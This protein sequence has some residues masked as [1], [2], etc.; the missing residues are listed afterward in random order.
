[1]ATKNDH[2]DYHRLNRILDMP[3]IPDSLEKSLLDN[4]EN[5]IAENHELANKQ[6]RQRFLFSTS[7][8]ASLFLGLFVMLRINLVAPSIV[9]AYEHTQE[10]KLLTGQLDGGYRQWMYDKNIS[11]PI[12]SS[13]IVLSKNCLL[14]NIKTKHLRFENEINMF[15][16]APQNNLIDTTETTGEFNGHKWL[17]L[18]PARN[19]HV[20]VLYENDSDKNQV[21]DIIKSMFPHQNILLI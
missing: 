4:L 21:D 11:L 15:F 8:A 7:I 14:G 17:V 1:M 20:L 13:P 2:H 12:N 18:K 9:H 6:K 19:V 3:D 5:Q 10:E 16:Y